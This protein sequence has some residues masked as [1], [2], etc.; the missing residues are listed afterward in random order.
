MTDENEK[1]EDENATSTPAPTAPGDIPDPGKSVPST[2][3]E[4][5]EDKD[6]DEHKD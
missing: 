4:K 2:E 5:H 1:H 6:K 3:P